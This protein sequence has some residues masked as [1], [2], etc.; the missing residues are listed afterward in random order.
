MELRFIGDTGSL[1]D[2]T[3]LSRYG[4]RFEMDQAKA[5]EWACGHPPGV[6]LPSDRFDAI[7][8]PGPEAETTL[9]K[10]PSRLSQESAPAEFKAQIRAAS[11]DRDEWIAGLANP[12]LSRPG[13]AGA[14]EN[15]A[16][17]EAEP[18]Q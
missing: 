12:G 17:A 8:Q 4:Q 2:G 13:L 11:V 14:N 1:P 3:A 18:G 10:Y 9:A 5:E 6:F 15:A 7:F 16:A